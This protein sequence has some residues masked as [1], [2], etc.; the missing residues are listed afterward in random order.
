MTTPWDTFAKNEMLKVMEQ[1]IGKGRVGAAT[2]GYVRK[3][4]AI[5]L[6]RLEALF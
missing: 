2:W 3:S 1:W 5:P 6:P 4:K